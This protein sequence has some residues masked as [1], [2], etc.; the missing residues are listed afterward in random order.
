MLEMVE[1][2]A[3]FGGE[4]R[5]YHHFSEVIGLSMRFSVYLPP[6]ALDRKVPAVFYLAGLTCNEQTFPIK[7]G[8]QRY[9]A[10]YGVAVVC[11]DT[12][13]RNAGLPWEDN[14]W[15]FG[16]GAGFYLDATEAPWSAHYK[17]YSYIRDEL[18]ELVVEHLPID[19]ERLGVFGHSM[20]G[21]GALVLAL[22][23]PAIYRS[24]SAFAPIGAPVQCPWGIGAFS[25]YLGEN[26][27]AWKHYDATELVSS[28]SCRF[29]G[30][31]L[32]DQGLD[33]AFLKTQ[34]HPHLFQAAC[35]AAGQPLELRMHEKYGHDY[36]FVSTFVG[37]H[38][39]HHADALLN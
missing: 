17:M 38:L 15:E 11:P 16:V 14:S 2:H 35:L 7:G 6:Q 22:R 23:N 8:A 26:R 18:R 31:I 39:A 21:H 28:L 3:C 25:G 4:Q 34:L 1:S 33:D 20:G 10:E 5:S 29:P 24:V 32:I 12:S 36:F 27:D 19:G 13:P 30:R 37:D 9:A